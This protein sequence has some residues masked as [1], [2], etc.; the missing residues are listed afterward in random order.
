MVTRSEGFTVVEL[1][2]A[3]VLLGIGLVG[4]AGLMVHSQTLMRR[5]ETREWAARVARS[6]A[7][8][9]GVA[10]GA[11]DGERREPRG[12]VAWTS[13][14]EGEVLRIRIEVDPVGEAAT[15]VFETARGPSPPEGAR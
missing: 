8:S 3:L 14:V 15:L 6:L 2:L 4:S 12:R 9:I 1:V 11:S 10:G 7:D 5:A 13:W